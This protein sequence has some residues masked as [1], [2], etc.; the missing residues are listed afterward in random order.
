MTFQFYFS[1]HKRRCFM[2]FIVSALAAVLLGCLQNYARFHR[3]AQVSDAFQRGTVSPKLNYFYAGR[4]NMPHAIMGLNPDYTNSSSLWIAFEPRPEY[5]QKMTS[6][7][8]GR[9]S[10]APH[11]YKILTPDGEFVGIWFSSIHFPSVELD[12]RNRTVNVRY[13]NPDVYREH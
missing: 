4:E 7:I 13:S 9:D 11:G 5:L 6:N 3:D 12:Q 2:L 10:Y 1:M 8:Y